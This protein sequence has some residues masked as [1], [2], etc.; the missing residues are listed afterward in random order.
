MYCATF[1]F[2][3]NIVLEDNVTKPR[4]TGIKQPLHNFHLLQSLKYYSEHGVFKV[5]VIYK[6]QTRLNRKTKSILQ[7]LLHS[8]LL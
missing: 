1:I 6:Q 7:I 2:P 5:S 4:P 3:T 8:T